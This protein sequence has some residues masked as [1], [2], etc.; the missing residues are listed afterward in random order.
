[1]SKDVNDRSVDGSAAVVGLAAAFGAALLAAPR[2]VET[3]GQLD[4]ATRVAH[5]LRR[6]GFGATPAELVEHRSLGAA[7]TVERLLDPGSAKDDVEEKLGRFGFDETRLGDIQREWV[8]R[9][10]YSSR[11]LVEKMTLFWH[12]LLTSANSKVGRP[13]LMRAQNGF[14]REH[15][16]GDF[17][18]ILKG[19]SRDPAMMLWLDTHNSRRANPNENYA[20]ELLELFSM[21]LG[22]YGEGDVREA[23]RAFT[24][25]TVSKQGEPVFNKRQFDPGAKSF[26]G[27]IV[28][29]PEEV[30]DTLIGHPATGRFVAGKLFAFFAFPGADAATVEPFAEVFRRTGGSIREVVRAILTSDVFYS[31]RAYR[32]RLK[33]PVEYA[34]GALRSLGVP[35]DGRGVVERMTRMGQQLYNPPNVAGWPGGRAWLNSGTWIERLNYANGLTALRGAGPLAS[36]DARRHLEERGLRRTDD[37]VAHVLDLL[38]DGRTNAAARRVL[39]DYMGVPPKADL[40][41]EKRRLDER[42]RGLVYL[43]IAMPE[44]QLC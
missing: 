12:G 1:V 28:T 29:A 44:Y 30:V 2:R 22:H 9:M 25:W 18:T 36:F 41:A 35:T 42:V 8:V 24:G 3:D 39:L 19:V 27:T 20:R 31:A 32:S 10:V 37:V 4:E 34:L 33:S 43:V 6:A 5:L 11:P 40:T 21:G 26:L 17:G 7:A 14:F 13:A 16:L 15:A 23:A 38:V